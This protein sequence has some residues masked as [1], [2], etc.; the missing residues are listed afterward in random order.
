MHKK[1]RTLL[2]V[3]AIAVALSPVSANAFML[4]WKLGFDGTG[5]GTAVTVNEFLDVVGP[6]IITTSV[7]VGGTFSFSEHGAVN[8]VGHDGGVPFGGST[9]I[10]AVLNITGTATLGGVISY[11]GG[12]IDVFFNPTRTFATAGNGTYGVDPAGSILIG[13]FSPV[14]GNGLIDTA[15]IPN[16]QQTISAEATMLKA[17]FWF[18]STGIDLSTLLD[19]HPTFG[20]ATTNASFVNPAPTLVTN[21]LGGGSV[22]NCLPGQL[23]GVCTGSGNFEI[24]NNGQFRLNAVPEP[25]S[26]LLIAAAVISFGFVR[27]RRNL[28]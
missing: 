16:G 9:Q 7:P 8:V 2:S 25:S 4:D 13:T 5:L 22:T 19:A 20:F 17:G 1:F 12:T 10:A 6:S 3:A 23:T 28:R 18:D 14:I 27:R 21:E 15:G 26:L 24:S 11:T